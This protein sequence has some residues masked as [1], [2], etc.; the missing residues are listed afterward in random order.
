MEI[1]YQ[2]SWVRHGCNSTSVANSHLFNYGSKIDCEYGCSGDI[3][4]PIS[5]VCKYFSI[6]DDWSFGEYHKTYNF[7]SI[8][9]ETTVTIGTSSSS[10][11][12]EIGG[13]WNVSTTFSL[14]TRA[15][16][17]KINSS[18]QVLPTPPLRL[19]Q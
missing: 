16:T 14:I 19:Q 13:S 17:G 9:D 10:W 4:S 18:P 7:T 5:Y 8:S 15:D 1:S 2:I 3:I 11:I 6:E 12:D